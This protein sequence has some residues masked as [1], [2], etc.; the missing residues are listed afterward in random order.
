MQIIST[1]IYLCKDNEKINLNFLNQIWI[2]IIIFYYQWIKCF[3]GK[4]KKYLKKIWFKS[5]NKNQI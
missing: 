2:E 5:L 1:I 3:S 4:E